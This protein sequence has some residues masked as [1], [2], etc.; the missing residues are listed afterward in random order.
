VVDKGDT[1]KKKAMAWDSSESEEDM[2][3]LK[4]SSYA[5]PKK[6]GKPFV[7]SDD[8][9]D[10]DDV[11]KKVVARTSRQKPIIKNKVIWGDEDSDEKDERIDFKMPNI[12]VSEAEKESVEEKPVEARIECEFFLWDC[13]IKDRN[14]FRLVTEYFSNEDM[15]LEAT[16]NTLIGI[17]KGGEVFFE[18]HV[19]DKNRY[20]SPN[21]LL[22]MVEIKL[23]K[24]KQHVVADKL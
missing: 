2:E 8:D 22:H 21:A 18:A 12:P 14:S 7:C 17:Q 24:C 11:D 1:F 16:F 20:V 4:K 13:D 19:K 23:R 5:P 6:T 15:V 3:A 9:D 10:F